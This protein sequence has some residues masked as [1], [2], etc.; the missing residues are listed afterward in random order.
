MSKE[1]CQ[2]CE[3]SEKLWKKHKP[4]TGYPPAGRV[5]M[6]CLGC[7]VRL[8]LSA[9]PDRK[10]AQAMLASIAAAR[11]RAEPCG[12]AGGCG[13]TTEVVSRGEV[14]EVPDLTTNME[15]QCG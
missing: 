12:C 7:C 9:H 3:I 8:V 2:L 14:F 10:L 5:Q 15:K 11:G 6:Q 4:A 13:R 1:E